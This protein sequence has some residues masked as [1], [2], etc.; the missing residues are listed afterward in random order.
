M[1]A[2][3]STSPAPVSLKPDVIS[4]YINGWKQLWKHF[5]ALFLIF[6][7]TIGFSIAVG[8]MELIPIFGIIV[9]IAYSIFLSGPVG[10]GQSFAYLKASRG[11]N[12]EVQDVF[13]AFKN[14]WNAV[15]ASIL[16][17]IIII[18]GFIFV[19]V[20]GIFLACKLAFVPYLVVDKKLGVIEAIS[21]SWNMT[22]GHGWE[23]FLI[24]LLGIPIGIA[25]LICL[26][27]GVIISGMW[28]GTTLASLYHAVDME[29]TA[30]PGSAAPPPAPVVG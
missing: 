9:G 13:S 20:P 12:V 19:I 2:Q 30:T 22:K 27:V 10:Y 6:L 1:Q 28:I 3:G 29:K 8:V 21:A 4:S 23:V 7:V 11:E 24:G 5:L 26:G 18:V 14:Y 17:G 15:G 25:G 16:T